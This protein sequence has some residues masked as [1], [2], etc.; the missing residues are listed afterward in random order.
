M[1]VSRFRLV[2]FRPST[3]RWY[4]P[5][6]LSASDSFNLDKDVQQTTIYCNDQ[7][8]SMCVSEFFYCISHTH[9]QNNKQ[10]CLRTFK[11]KHL[12]TFTEEHYILNQSGTTYDIRSGTPTLWIKVEHLTKFRVKHLTTFSET[13]DDILIQSGIP[14]NIQGTSNTWRH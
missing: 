6:N 10:T 7:L 11:M 14:G 1:S 5:F 3:N 13:P 9:Q 4:S 2:S 12:I 8:Y